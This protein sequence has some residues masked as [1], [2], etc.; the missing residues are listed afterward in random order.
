MAYRCDPCNLDF[1]DFQHYLD[2]E[3][4]FHDEQLLTQVYNDVW[5][6]TNAFNSFKTSNEGNNGNIHLNEEEN[7]CMLTDNSEEER[8][9]VVDF[10]K[11]YEIQ[12]CKETPNES[13]ALGQR[14]NNLEY[15]S[16]VQ[17]STHPKNLEPN[18]NH[19]STSFGVGQISENNAENSSNLS[20][21][22]TELSSFPL[23]ICGVNPIFSTNQQS[24]S[25]TINRKEYCNNEMNRQVKANELAVKNENEPKS[26]ISPPSHR[27]PNII[28][29][30]LEK[31][32]K[33]NQKSLDFVG[34]SNIDCE[35]PKQGHN[36]RP[37]QRNMNTTLKTQI[38]RT[39]DKMFASYSSLIKYSNV[40]SKETPSE[41]NIPGQ[42]LS[43]I[44]NAIEC[45]PKDKQTNRSGS[46][47]EK[48]QEHSSSSLRRSDTGEKNKECNAV[49]NS[50]N[51][52]PILVED[53]ATRKILCSAYICYEFYSHLFLLVSAISIK[54]NFRVVRVEIILI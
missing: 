34:R 8:S 39:Q 45:D 43:N 47:E 16:Q 27:R 7:K 14:L 5:M 22:S 44:K 36:K 17:H 30:N 20:S 3:R 48:F 15:C 29:L 13:D 19:P 35:K 49:E 52:K 40:H 46:V 53:P 11:N 9:L 2:H 21:V 25:A 37:W 50:F 4:K 12:L 1:T 32:S 23:S 26:R 10:L 33:K 41:Q 24:V 54:T 38:E 51:V 31:Y 28:H 6:C 42:S 18:L